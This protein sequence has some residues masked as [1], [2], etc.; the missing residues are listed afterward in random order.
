[1][2]FKKSHTVF[3]L[4]LL[5]SII[6]FSCTE[7]DTTMTKKNITLNTN[8]VFKKEG[9]NHFMPAT[10][11]GTVHTDL[12]NNNK[13]P[14]PFYRNNEKKLQWI[15]K[16]NWIYQ[17]TFKVDS[18]YLS[19]NSI[20]LNFKGLD[21]YS[22]VYLNDSLILKT[23]NMF[24]SW[25]IDVKE[26][27]KV[28]ENTLK[29]RFI[30][31]IKT[32]I[33]KLEE[34]K[35]GLPAA[36]DQSENGGIGDKKVSVFTRKAPYHYGWDWGPR[37]V[38]SGIWRPVE[39][40]LVNKAE[41]SNAYFI[42]SEITPDKASG[43]CSI[44]LNIKNED[45]YKIQIINNETDEIYSTKTLKLVPGSNSVD[46]E[47]GID[48][49]KLWWPAG[50]GNQN[51]YKL[52]IK[53]STQDLVLDKTNHN[54][55]IR[56]LKVVIKPDSTGKSFYF[57]VNGVP[58]FAKG[59]NYIP[60]DNFLT[61]I[62][63]K[64][65][66]HIIRSAVD[67]NMNMLRVWG[68]GIYENDIFYDL[69]DKYGLLIWQDFMFACSMYPGNDEFLENVRKEAIENV[70]RL[71]N[72]PSVALWC[73]NNEID[74][75]WCTSSMDCGWHWKQQYTSQER[76]TI[77]KAYDTLFHK[78]LPGIIKKYDPERLYWPSSPK[79]GFEPEEQASYNSASGDIHYWGVWHGSEPFEAFNDNVGRFMSEY[80]FQSYPEF[81]SIQEFTLPQDWNINSEVMLTHQRSPIGNQK[82][83]EYMKKYFGVPDNFE[84]MIYISHLLQNY[85]IQFAIE[86]HRLAKPYCMG[87]LYWQ[88]N[89]CWPGAS[90]SSIDYYGN[91]KAQQYGARESY[92]PVK[93]IIRNDDSNIKVSVVS[94]NKKVSKADYKLRCINF[95][96]TDIFTEQ[97]EIQVS[98]S[99]T[100]KI[101]ERTISSL[102]GENP[103]EKVAIVGELRVLNNVIDRQIH[104][105]VYP[106]DIQLPVDPGVSFQVEQIRNKY[107]IHLETKKLAKNVYLFLMKDNG[108]FSDNY[109]DLLP[110]EKKEVTL[111]IAKKGNGNHH[112]KIKFYTLNQVKKSLK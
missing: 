79:A 107:I 96:G 53:L 16:E 110:G 6:L 46:L 76:E 67:A 74:I 77:W 98:F 51:I 59:A 11:P 18:N 112:P 55:G 38:T 99:K 8:W 50:Y 106:K 2:K 26:L 75:A 41:I 23:D 43:L 105:L 40:I 65:Y 37:L 13:I 5:I 12:L 58:I 34:Y 95:S 30:S 62:T 73:G 80:G 94:D 78:I 27:L 70:I 25:R 97:K 61:D 9:D 56:D 64:E 39:L 90:W 86:T 19:Y 83:D 93:L 100:T 1:M 42:V 108:H 49:P 15:D 17:T 20:Y 81:K 68:G 47:F 54:L 29:V 22:E 45:T 14:Q 84:E 31:P 104:Y 89:D 10:V 3:R 102:I 92:K 57:Q 66:E 71:R 32:G 52:S 82:I 63:D 72:H 87:T 35:I 69:C 101:D 24:R 36:N 21:T 109:F 4:L 44:D 33:A 85:G 28:G 111:T 91:W 48:K 88:L 60:N 7:E 103:K